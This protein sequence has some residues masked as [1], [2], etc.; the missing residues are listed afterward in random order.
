ML[1]LAFG[2]VACSMRHETEPVEHATQGLV[3][4]STFSNGGFT[5]LYSNSTSDWDAVIAQ[6]PA[7]VVLG[8]DVGAGSSAPSYFKARSSTIQVLT[9]IPM[10]YGN[11]GTPYNPQCGITNLPDGA[12][13]N[14]PTSYNCGAV[15][16]QSRI[17]TAMES[18]YD[19]VFFDETPTDKPTYVASCAASVKQVGA[20][21]LVI[22]NPGSVPPISMFDDNVDIVSVEH[23]YTADLTG[24]GIPAWRWLAVEDGVGDSATATSRLSTFQTN[25]GFWYYGAPSLTTVPSWLATE[26]NAS[27]PGVPNCGGGGGGG[28]LVP[29]GIHTFNRADNATITGLYTTIQTTD[30]TVLHTGFTGDPDLMIAPGTYNV[31]AADYGPYTFDHWDDYSTAQPRTVTVPASPSGLWVGAWYTVQ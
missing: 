29:I 21:K 27:E 23:D 22:L 24:T 28:A 7:F 19:G 17:S 16:I 10:N 4:C 2:L 8:D 14:T 12:C 1:C 30:G 3:A 11:N 15:A 25:G 13:T 20:Q 6:A 18:G 31:T 26:M 9:Y 5:V